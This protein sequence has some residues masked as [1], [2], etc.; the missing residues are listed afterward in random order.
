MQTAECLDMLS[1]RRWAERSPA[2]KV[3]VHKN[4]K[5]S[6]MDMIHVDTCEITELQLEECLKMPSMIQ[7]S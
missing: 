2:L 3:Y 5:L 1:E 4:P 7:K 6:F